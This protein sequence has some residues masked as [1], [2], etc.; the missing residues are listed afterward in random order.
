MDISKHE[1]KKCICFT[2]WKQNTGIFAEVS[3]VS[4]K[5]LLEVVVTL[6]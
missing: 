3:S 5:S 4:T 2:Q 1:V 6:R